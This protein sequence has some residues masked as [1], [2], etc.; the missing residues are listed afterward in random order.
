[1]LQGQRER[2]GNVAGRVLLHRADVEDD[3]LAGP[4]ALEQLGTG[5]PLGALAAGA[6]RAEDL[7]DLRQACPAEVAERGDEAADL[8]AGGPVVDAG[9]L[10]AGLDE[11]GLAHHLQVRGRRRELEARRRSEG[12][13]AALG[14]AEQVEQVDALGVH[15]HLADPGELLVEVGPSAVWH[16]IFHRSMTL[17]PRTCVVHENVVAK[18]W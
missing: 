16:L 14:L 7:V 10:P 15:D 1:M 9:S 3:D 17:P 8:L 2:P 5:H 11:A 18:D 12:L 6:D 13:D 4:G